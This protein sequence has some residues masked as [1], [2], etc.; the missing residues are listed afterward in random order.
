M[1]CYLPAEYRQLLALPPVYGF[2]T[3]GMDAGYA[4]YF[5]ELFFTRLRATG[6]GCCF[7]GG[8]L[9]SASLLVFSSWLKALPG[10]DLRLAV[11]LLGGLF[12]LGVLIV[13][14]L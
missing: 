10:M 1:T 3:L 9:A 2:F 12:L 13:C 11:R 6:P 14:F 8:R 5:L 7:N 4:V